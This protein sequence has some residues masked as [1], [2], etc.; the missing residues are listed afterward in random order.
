MKE[1]M[2]KMQHDAMNTED[3]AM[4]VDPPSPIARHMMWKM[5]HI[6]Q[7]GHMAFKA[8]QEISDKIVS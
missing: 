1:K 5:T 3:S 6:K 2:K 7:Y 4:I 8:T